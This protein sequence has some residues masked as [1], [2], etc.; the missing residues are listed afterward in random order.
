MYEYYGHRRDIIEIK[1]E[2]LERCSLPIGPTR[3]CHGSNVQW[4]VFKTI[5]EEFLEK[6]FIIS[7]D[8]PLKRRSSKPKDGR[9]KKLYQITK[10]GA[11]VLKKY[12]ELR[13]MGL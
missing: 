11:Q 5:L 13:D 6:K 8:P 10:L 1:S 12:N 4:N 7:I 9:R 2:I 3:L